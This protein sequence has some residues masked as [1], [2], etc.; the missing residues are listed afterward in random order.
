MEADWSDFQDTGNLKFQ[1][2]GFPLSNFEK[3]WIAEIV[4]NWGTRGSCHTYHILDSLKANVS[5]WIWFRNRNPEL[6]CFAI[7]KNSIMISLSVPSLK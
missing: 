5:R 4:L 6:L 3:P 1:Y 7:L 2:L